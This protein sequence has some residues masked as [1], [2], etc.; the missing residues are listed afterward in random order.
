M[1]QDQLRLIIS[2]AEEILSNTAPLEFLLDK[3]DEIS[4][5]KAENMQRI[6]DIRQ[7]PH[8]GSQNMSQGDIKPDMT[9]LMDTLRIDS[10]EAYDQALNTLAQGIQSFIHELMPEDRPATS[11]VLIKLKG[12]QMDDAFYDDLSDNGT[13]P[14]I[15]RLSQDLFVFT[16]KGKPSPAD[17]EKDIHYYRVEY[18]DK[19]IH[20][21][22][23]FDEL[24]SL[25]FKA[26][27]NTAG[28]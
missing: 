14:F 16:S 21:A 24:I 18:N 9:E 15:P 7:L 3:F 6:S 19:V 22:L 20:E 4:T 28:K 13:R 1:N 11:R 25:D 12:T 26:I 27:I 5:L 10:E 8:K 2:R 17:Q 23:N